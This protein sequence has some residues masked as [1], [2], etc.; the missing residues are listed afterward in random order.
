M[1]TE[2]DGKLLVVEDTFLIAMQLQMD[3]KSLGYSVA[4]PAPSVER[5]FKLLNRE[6]IKAALLDVH[7]GNENSIPI[8]NKLKELGI[9]FLFITGFERVQVDSKEFDEHI[10]LRK[11]INLEQL[12]TAMQKLLAAND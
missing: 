8:A 9:P 6:T 12:E 7:L 1:M 10:L 11:P 3:L 5:A 4:G 2:Q